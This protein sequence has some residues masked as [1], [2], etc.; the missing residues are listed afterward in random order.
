MPHRTLIIGQGL[1]GSVLAWQAA[2]RGDQLIVVDAGNSN[3]ASAVA[4]GL[5]M[6]LSGQRLVSRPDYPALLAAAEACYRRIEQ[7]T[8]QTLFRSRIIERRFVSAMERQQWEDR[9]ASRPVYHGAELLSSPTK[10]QNTT[11]EGE[12][13]AE[14]PHSAPGRDVA[15]QELRPPGG[16]SGQNAVARGPLHNTEDPFAG[17]ILQPLRGPF[18]ALLMSG[19]QLNVPLLLQVTRDHLLAA[20]QFL[21]RP[22]QAAHVEVHGG[23]VRVAEIGLE[24]DRIFFCEGHRGRS[25]CWFPGQPDQPVRGELLRV[26][27]QRPLSADVVVGQVW[28]APVPGT[29]AAAE[30]LIGATWDRERLEEGL[31]TAAGRTELLEG[32]AT[33]LDL[34]PASI[35]Q[36]AAATTSDLPP[37]STDQCAPATSSGVRPMSIGRCDPATLNQYA[38]VLAQTSG[39]RAG[40]R[41]RQVLVRLHPTHPQLG[42]LNGLGSWGSL[43]APAAATALLD[44]QQES[45]RQRP[46]G[47]PAGGAPAAPAEAPPSRPQPARRSLTKL[48]H[49]MARRAY[50]PGDRVFDATAGNGHDTEFL[51]TL[52]GPAAVTAID[53]QPQAIDATR[54]RLGPAADAVLLIV[55]DH[56]AVLELQCRDAGGTAADDSPAY[57][58]IMFNLGYLPGSDRRVVTQAETTRRALQAGLQLLRPRGVLTAIVYRG[59]PG[60]A[61]EY[62]AVEQLAAAFPDLRVDVVPGDEADETSPVLFAFRAPAVIHS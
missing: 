9:V 22:F 23:G 2:W 56:A 57:G 35:A 29:E 41:Q 18:G 50:R 42:M 15:Q 1:A 53:I 17:C 58:V 30:Y 52:A 24:A 31:V 47:E 14:P 59:H 43:T 10:T 49:S 20:H 19:W 38:E 26:R 4:A 34:P 55:G 48:A 8:G 36:D 3:T 25:N 6:P 28:A 32:L 33:L 27:L 37:T 61:A 62:A 16:A 12:A 11:R 51:V 45:Q 13:P 40:T 60:G 7:E 44:L 21:Q 54:R 39:I 46:D 5:V